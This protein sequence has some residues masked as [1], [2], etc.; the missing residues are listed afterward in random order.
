MK[1]AV[2]AV[3]VG[4]G[5][6]FANLPGSAAPEWQMAGSAGAHMPLGDYGDIADTGW[7]GGVQLEYRQRKA[8][9]YGVDLFYNATSGEVLA[10]DVDYSILQVGAHVT[11]Y[12]KMSGDSPL[13]PYGQIAF[14]YY[15]QTAES[16]NVDDTEGDVGLSFV[17]GLLYMPSTSKI[18]FGV[19]LALHNVFQVDTTQY[20]NINAKIVI[21]FSD[22]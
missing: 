16:G 11:G 12:L 22:R 10:A 6:A 18:G 5:L 13:E 1:T 19:D 4:C 20:L 14:S 2:A 21:S 8:F 15:N 3:I 17:G 7:N 9:G